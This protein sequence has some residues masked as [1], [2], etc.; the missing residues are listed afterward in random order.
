MQQD[1]H[2]IRSGKQCNEVG[3]NKKIPKLLRWKRKKAKKNEVNHSYKSVFIKGI[4]V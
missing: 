2:K 3:K 4:I 1:L